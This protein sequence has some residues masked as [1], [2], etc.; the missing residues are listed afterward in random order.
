MSRGGP[1]RNPRMGGKETVK[2][3]AR[4]CRLLPLTKVRTSTTILLWSYVNQLNDLADCLNCDCL[5]SGRLVAQ[6]PLMR[7]VHDGLTKSLIPHMET[8]EAAVFPTLERLA[9]DRGTMV[10]M[11][12]EHREIRPSRCGARGVHRPSAGPRRSRGRARPAARP[13]S[14]VRVAQDAPDRR[15]V[16]H[17]D[18]RGSPD[19]RGGGGPRAG[20]RPPGGRAAVGRGCSSELPQSGATVRCAT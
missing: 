10:P 2:G 7:E 4:R 13:H 5:D 15:G 16:V 3:A 9:A 1:R 11:T 18:P 20:P 14:T 12:T 19:A 17:P 8:V 6:L